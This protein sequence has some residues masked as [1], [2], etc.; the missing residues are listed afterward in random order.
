MRRAETACGRR[1]TESELRVSMAAARRVAR[2]L[3]PTL[4]ASVD[5]ILGTGAARTERDLAAGS[6]PAHGVLAASCA[7]YPPPHPRP[8]LLSCPRRRRLGPTSSRSSA[9]CPRRR[10]AGRAVT[11]HSSSLESAPPSPRPAPSPPLLSCGLPRPPS[12]FLPRP[13]GRLGL[14]L[15]CPSLSCTRS[16]A[17]PQARCDRRD[18]A[19]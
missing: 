11:R 15:P 4:Q 6:P 2:P 18:L 8:P 1:D 13:S 7:A 12:S 9:C 17:R 5:S 16:H 10:A 14:S 19:R 3:V